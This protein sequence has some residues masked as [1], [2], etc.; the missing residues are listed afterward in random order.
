MVV[1]SLLGLHAGIREK[2]HFMSVDDSEAAALPKDHPE[3]ALTHEGC[4]LEHD[5]EAA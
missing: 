2:G 3:S 1:G 4:T 5:S